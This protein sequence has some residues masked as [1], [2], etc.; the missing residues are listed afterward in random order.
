MNSLV[1]ISFRHKLSIFSLLASLF[2]SQCNI[3]PYQIEMLETEKVEVESTITPSVTLTLLP[4][5][6]N[7]L[8]PSD[9]ATI[10]PTTTQTL[11]PTG[12]F[13]PSPTPFGGISGLIAYQKKQFGDIW[14]S[15]IDGQNPRNLT[16]TFKG[17]ITRFYWSQDGEWILFSM[18]AN[19]TNSGGVSSESQSEL[20]A[21]R[22]DG[23]EAHYIWNFPKYAQRISLSSDGTKFIANCNSIRIC[24]VSFN[25]FEITRLDYPGDFMGHGHSA[26]RY[27]PGN[28]SFAWISNFVLYVATGIEEQP[29]EVPLPFVNFGY[30]FSWLS[31]TEILINARQKKNSSLLYTFSTIDN[32][33]EEK[34]RINYEFDLGPILS[35]SSRILIRSYI[36][37]DGGSRYGPPGLMDFDGNILVWFD[38]IAMAYVVLSPDSKSLIACNFND[39]IFDTIDPES[40]TE[41]PIEVMDWLRCSN[42]GIWSFQPSQ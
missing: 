5:T 36:S 12:T 21:V 30:G 9:T 13:T 34:K 11:T 39:G 18:V 16:E 25:N 14:I 38:N 17:Y 35:K 1:I 23:T 29:I 37:V 31:D 42:W 33:L 8:K 26:P 22:P 28:N 6:T 32:K 2:V 24:I 20:W 3:S 19:L 7:T 40:Y 15:S 41:T 4:T 27:S 10:S